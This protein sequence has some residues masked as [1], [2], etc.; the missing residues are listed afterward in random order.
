MFGIHA[1]SWKRLVCLEYIA[2]IALANFSL[3]PLLHTDVACL[4]PLAAAQNIT[5]T[6]CNVPVRDRSKQYIAL[7]LAMG[8]A[9]S[10]TVIAR[11]VFKRRYN[12]GLDTDD[13]LTGSLLVTSVATMV[14]NQYGLTNNGLGRDVWTITLQQLV[15]LHMYFW[16]A[17]IVYFWNVG[18]LKVV[19]LVFYLRIFASCSRGIVRLLWIFLLGTAVCMCTFVLLVIFLCNPIE[20]AWNRWDGQHQGRCLNTNLVG[21]L[22]SWINLAL[23]IG[24]FIIP[25]S[26][27]GHLKLHWKQKISVGAMFFLGTL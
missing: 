25:L 21:V 15:D 5:N 2:S 1:P 20:F 6:A 3:D 11:L 16:I 12:L 9:G 7:S 23:D 22:Q 19:L 26:Q 14:L 17:S 13:W 24:V 27:L 18:M 10:F 8:I 4:H